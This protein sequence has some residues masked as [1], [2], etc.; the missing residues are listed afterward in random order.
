MDNLHSE[1]LAVA[2][3]PIDM[4]KNV[5][6]FFGEG[7]TW[8]D[9]LSDNGKTEEQI[10]EIDHKLRNHGLMK[11]ARHESELSST[12]SRD[13]NNCSRH[14]IVRQTLDPSETYYVRF[15]SVLDGT[16]WEL[17]LDYFEYCPKEIYDSPVTPEDIW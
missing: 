5:E 16:K 10:I 2:G 11:G 17:Y 9:D 15:K 12:T 13:K 8:G 7:A 1:K 3:I 14:I 4:T 6:T